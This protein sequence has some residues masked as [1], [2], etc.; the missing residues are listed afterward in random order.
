MARRKAR[1]QQPKSPIA[2]TRRGAV[3]LV[4]L[5]RPRKHNAIDGAMLGALVKFFNTPPKGVAAVVLHSTSKNFS[6]GLDLSDIA[7]RDAIEVFD[8]SRGWHAAIDAMRH[9]GLPIVAALS[10]AVIGGG[11]ELAMAAHVRVA[12]RTATYRM[13]EG[14]HGIFTGG[15]AS[16]R[17]ARAIGIDRLTEM[18]LTGRVV[19]AEEGLIMGLS[20]I[21]ADDALATAVALAETIT[22][23][24]STSNR[25][26]VQGLDHIA[27]MGHADGLFTESLIVALT[28]TTPEAK[29]RV[30]GFLGKSKKSRNRS[31]AK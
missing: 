18:M 22:E 12:D 1:P 13:P 11:V 4:G 23:N 14:R 3:A 2:V 15:G 19:D 30:A 26:I 5:D 10:G 16:V 29:A 31:K 8:H 28:Q 25:M 27:E 20:H 17:V 24:A 21:L 6:A 9:N 7:G